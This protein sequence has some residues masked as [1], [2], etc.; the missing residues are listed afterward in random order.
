MESATPPPRLGP[1]VRHN[2]A[3]NETDPAVLRRLIA[4]NPWGTL[5]SVNDGR[6]IASHYP[7]LLDDGDELVLLT[8]VGRPDERIHDFD[9]AMLVIVAGP[10]GYVSPSWYSPE[11]TPA[12]TWNFSVAH[13]YGV[14]EIL[15]LE[16]NKE[17]LSRLVAHFEQHVDDPHYLAR[18]TADRL[19]P[20]T[21]GLRIPITEWTLKMKMSQDKTP[22]SRRR[23]LDELRGPGPY[24]NPALANDMERALVEGAF[25]H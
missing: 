17:T 7:L 15:D 14:P 21:V 10:H 20:G 2:P 18:E 9:G 5:I 12:P 3:H 6:P 25:E 19:A 23:V 1:P 16:S 8:H 13:C 4:E 24:G 11:D 22:A